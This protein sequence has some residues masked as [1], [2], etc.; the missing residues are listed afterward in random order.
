VKPKDN[1]IT[2]LKY[3]ETYYHNNYDKQNIITVCSKYDKYWDMLTQNREIAP[4]N[5]IEIGG[6]PGRYLAYIAAKY[7]I[8]PICLDYNSNID[9]CKYCF[10][11]MG[12]SNY[13]LIN[14]DFQ[15]YETQKQYDIV[16]S[17]GFIEHF[18]D[19]DKILDKHATFLN[20]GGKM[21]ITVPNKRNIRYLYG[22]LLDN[23]NLKQ[24]NI[25]CMRKKVFEDFAKRNNLEIISFSYFGGFPY[26]VHQELNFAQKILYKVLK[27]TFKIINPILEKYPNKYTCSLLIC[28]LKK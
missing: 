6:F 8:E 5:I 10:D 18:N 4:K 3:W 26:A 11:E 20:K 24:H 9:N 21:M 2:D 19:Y 12:I 14:A 27:T 7:K 13:E 1:N 17:H 15:K 23:E 28:I 22:L 16:F 25:A